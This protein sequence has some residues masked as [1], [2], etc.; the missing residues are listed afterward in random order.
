[1]SLRKIKFEIP[2]KPTPK[3]RP[4]YG[5][6]G[7]VYTPKKTVE[8]ENL[9]RFMFIQTNEKAF[10]DNEAIKID[11]NFYFKVPDSYTKKRKNNIYAGKELYTK[12]PDIDNLIKSVL[13]GLN[14]YAYA[15]DKQII[16]IK[17]TKNYISNKNE[18][19]RAEITI[20]EIN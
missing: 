9:I 8:Y 15:D 17:A 4:R 18:N 6:Y 13:D 14:G 11:I 12:K 3:G 5:K 7:T 20:Y 10:L 2:R 16:D 1:M 19:E